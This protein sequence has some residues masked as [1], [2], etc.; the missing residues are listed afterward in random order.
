MFHSL[1]PIIGAVQGVLQTEA[2]RPD[3]TIGRWVV[4]V[5]LIALVALWITLIAV[6]V[7]LHSRLATTATAA[8][9]ATAQG[10]DADAPERAGGE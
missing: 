2:S 10:L 9:D 3:G 5:L 6:V 4:A 7:R 8:A 1:E